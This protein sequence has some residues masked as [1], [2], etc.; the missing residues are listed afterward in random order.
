MHWLLLLSFIGIESFVALLVVKAIALLPRVWLRWS[1]WALLAIVS[2]FFLGIGAVGTVQV[3]L[4]GWG[5]DWRAIFSCDSPFP[6]MRLLVLASGFAFPFFLTITGAVGLTRTRQEPRRPRVNPG[7]FRRPFTGLFVASLVFVALLIGNDIAACRSLRALT[8]AATARAFEVVPPA[9]SPEQNAADYYQVPHH[10]QE[11]FAQLPDQ[12]FPDN[13]DELRNPAWTAYLSAN[14][15]TADRVRS[16]TAL[17]CCRFGTEWNNPSALADSPELHDVSRCATLLLAEGHRALLDGDDRLGFLNAMALRRLA[18]QVSR[19]P[20]ALAQVLAAKCEACSASLLEH[21]LY[22]RR[23]TQEEVTSLIRPGF[24][25]RAAMERSFAW[26]E[27]EACRGVCDTYLGE[28]NDGEP[29]G[30]RRYPVW[31]TA[32]PVSRLL[33]AGDDLAAIPQLFSRLRG[34]AGSSYSAVHSPEESTQS[35]MHQ[36]PRSWLERTGLAT[37]RAIPSTMAL[38]GVYYRADAARAAAD[39]AILLTHE[40]DV[41]NLSPAEVDAF[42]PTSRR[43]IDPFA[44]EPLHVAVADGGL[45]IY[46]LGMNCQDDG[47]AEDAGS[48]SRGDMAFCLGKS[49]LQ[50]RLLKSANDYAGP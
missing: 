43:P 13:L 46:S 18:E 25:F 27:A 11:S 23:P 8:A 48:A 50:R 7:D 3:L 37:S 36:T 10:Q 47:G 29:A 2:S 26:Q 40:T 44:G 1:T 45:I 19:D 49:F 15:V 33:F 24:E 28:A 14:A 34:R 38:F 42:V 12:R 35:L 41:E 22:V 17:G 31:L 16:G 20:R 30:P 6:T 4:R 5:D 21:C 39:F 9:C 32:N